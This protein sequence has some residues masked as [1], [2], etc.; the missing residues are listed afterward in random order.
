MRRRNLHGSLALLLVAGLAACGGAPT[1]QPEAAEPP[2]QFA[3]VATDEV[4]HGER[5]ARVL[6]CLGCHGEDLTGEDWSEPGF[7]S[8]WTANLTRIVPR[9]DDAALARTITGGVRPDGREL[10]EMPSHLFTQLSRADMAALIAYLRS[11]P[12]TGPERPAPVF[13]AGARREIEAGTFT[14]SAAQ[15]RA[16]GRQWPPE[17]AGD[18][19]LARYIVRATCAE[20]H[21]MNLAGGQPN[22]DATPRPDLRMVAAYPKEDFRRLLRTGIAAGNREVGMM[23]GVARVRYRHLTD[24]EVDA[25]HAYLQ[26]LGSRP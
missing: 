20:C 6:G 21:R 24:A 15:V 10:W 19:R 14:S 18:H 23:S 16:E 22:P 8:L 9:R 4:R 3:R 2:I 26:A 25:V 17:V 1:K 12:P 5:L 11:R 7:G 13:E